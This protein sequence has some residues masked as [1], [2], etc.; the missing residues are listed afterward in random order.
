MHA[1]DAAPTP[2]AP[3]AP[4]VSAGAMP[5]PA[6]PAVQLDAVPFAPQDATSLAEMFRTFP[7]F[8]QKFNAASFRVGGFDYYACQLDAREHPLSD[9]DHPAAA[10]YHLEA[11]IINTFARAANG[12]WQLSN[13]ELAGVDS[14]GEPPA[15]LNELHCVLQRRLAHSA[16]FSWPEQGDTVQQTTLTVVD[17]MSVHGTDMNANTPAD[18]ASRQRAHA[19]ALEALADEVAELRAQIA[20]TSYEP[21][22]EFLRAHFVFK[23]C[24]LETQLADE[25][26]CLRHTVAAATTTEGLPHES[27]ANASAGTDESLV[28]TR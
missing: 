24:M 21:M 27:E 26:A 17:E 28:Q 20:G 14:K 23:R 8:A 11:K 7:K 25:T 15:L 3:H 6:P 5:S 19:E 12:D 18:A 1:D 9:E 13:S 16:K 22:R 4:L 10:K 2:S